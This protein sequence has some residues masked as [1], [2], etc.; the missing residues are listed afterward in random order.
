MPPAARPGTRQGND[1]VNQAIAGTAAIAASLPALAG[2]DSLRPPAPPSLWGP[3]LWN[4]VRGRQALTQILGTLALF[5]ALVWF[6]GFLRDTLAQQNLSLGFDFLHRTAGISI[7]ETILPYL[8]EDSLGWLIVVGAANTLRVSILGCILASLIGVAVG[9]MRLSSNVL[10]GTLT[11][12]YVNVVRNTPLLLQILFWYAVLLQL[13][14]VRQAPSIGDVIYFSNR[15]LQVPSIGYGGDTAMLCVALLTGALAYLAVALPTRRPTRPHGRRIL[16]TLAAAAAALALLGGLGLLD[17]TTPERR[18]F[19]FVGGLTLTPEFAALVFAQSV[20]AGA[21]IAELVR[22]GIE[23]VARGQKEAGAS[24]G[25]TPGQVMRLVVLPQALLVIV[26]SVTTQY[27]SV[28]KNSSLAIAVGFPD[29]FW[30]LTSTI[31]LSGHSI[32]GIAIMLG[33]YLVPTLIAAAAMSRFN[34]RLVARGQRK[35]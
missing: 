25:L 11:G 7:A 31:T 29:L 32:E 26:P 22:G 17:I 28:I 3:A 21:F 14:T 24:I 33:A 9:V 27:V 4:T 6:A 16:A 13:P 23:S 8:P 12:I 30:A 20:Y 5:V 10:L 34:Q 1:I 2:E 15:G 18:G 35:G 19:N